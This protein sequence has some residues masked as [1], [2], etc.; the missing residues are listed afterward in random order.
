[1]HI[2]E[3][4]GYNIYSYNDN[5]TVITPLAIILPIRYSSLYLQDTVTSKQLVLEM[6]DNCSYIITYHNTYQ[7]MCCGLIAVLK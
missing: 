2:P 7:L 6:L 5:N 3:S 4:V 1:M